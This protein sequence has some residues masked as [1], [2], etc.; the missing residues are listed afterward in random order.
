M[1]MS[2]FG[3][4]GKTR[5]FFK[6]PLYKPLHIITPKIKFFGIAQYFQNIVSRYI[7]LKLK[8]WIR[9]KTL[10]CPSP[11]NELEVKNH[12]QIFLLREED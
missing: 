5:I 2:N 12:F 8:G 1:D 10:V 11:C 9:R 3:I 6:K 7:Y 4:Y